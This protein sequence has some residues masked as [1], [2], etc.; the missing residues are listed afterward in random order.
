[1]KYVKDNINEAVVKKHAKNPEIHAISDP[2]YQ[3]E[4]RFHKSRTKATWNLRLYEQGK[5]YRHRIGYWPVLSAKNAIAMV[6]D[7]LRRLGAGEELQVSEFSTVNDLLNWYLE[8]VEKEAAKSADR[9][10][11]V[12]SAIRTHLLPRLDGLLLANVKKVVIDQM[13]LLPLQGEGLK[14]STIR[15]YFAILK[16]VFASASELGLITVNPMA[17][18]KF[19]D[20]IQKRILPKFGKLQVQDAQRIKDIIM[21][22]PT[23]PRMLMLIMLMFATRIG[24]TRQLMWKHVDLEGRRIIIPDSITKTGVTHVL[25]L[26]DKSLQLLSE[27]RGKSHGTYLFG[28]NNPMSASTADQM[29][30]TASKGQFSAHDLRKMARSVWAEI[31]VDYW[32]A[33]QLLNHKPKGLDLVYIQA[34]SSK[35]K[36]D[37]LEKYHNWL[38]KA[39]NT[40]SEVVTT[41][42][43]NAVIL[44][45]NNWLA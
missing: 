7:V 13:L 3:I 16:R 25:P 38:F 34:D 22:Q 26:T 6:P 32:V 8:R 9:K 17:S 28:R 15:Q 36:K 24:E 42:N 1:M 45:F 29:I 44:Q 40:P 41:Q 4:L 31:G 43:E 37:A 11:N 39:E 30:R 10:K 33:E 27:F 2:R 5:I 23:K 18:M 12:K 19:S 21:E 35:V 20:H 14:P